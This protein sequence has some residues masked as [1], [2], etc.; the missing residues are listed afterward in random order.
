MALYK[1][2]WYGSG[3]GKDKRSGRRVARETWRAEEGTQRL[4]YDDSGTACGSSKE[5][6]RGAVG[7]GQEEAGEKDT[8]MSEEEQMTALGR[9]V[10]DAAE[11]KRRLAVLQHE[12]SR[13][14]MAFS[15]A[16]SALTDFLRD[17]SQDPA[18][19]VRDLPNAEKVAALLVEFQEERTRHL[20][21]Q[22][23]LAMTGI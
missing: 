1:R 8:A 19:M 15:G 5:G 7:Q 10:R 6:R 20:D 22:A 12:L 4:F 18:T 3:Y 16:A 21:L 11:S 2:L 14:S 23:R 9:L 17:P 13:V